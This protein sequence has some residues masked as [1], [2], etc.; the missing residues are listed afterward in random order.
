MRDPRE[1]I[2][3][4]H[5]HL[6]ALTELVNEF[7]AEAYRVDMQPDFWTEPAP[8]AKGDVII[9]AEARKPPPSLIWGP[10]IGDIVHGFR[11]ALDQA[12]WTLSVEFQKTLG[13]APPAGPIPRGDPWRNIW[14][15]ILQDPGQWAGATANQLWAI[16]QALLAQIEPLQPYRTGQNAPEREP[17]AVLQELW[18]IDKH[19]HLHLV[20]ATVELHDVVSAEP[21]PGAPH[22]KFAIVSQRAP[23][24]LVNR[25]EIGR[26]RMIR[27]PGGLLGVTL[28]QMHM[29]ALVAVDVAFDQ[30]YPAYGGRVVQTLR[31]IGQTVSA[32]VD[33]F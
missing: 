3:R 5:Q 22:L 31:Q 21:F 17:L 19:R 16:H 9:T 7:A 23:G 11:S 6:Y 1:K 12:A 26:A 28:P 8:P 14:F 13:N 10:I 33:A 24:P 20:N 25:A 18:N 27:E 30:G 15:P 29:D 2:N 4:A 32:I